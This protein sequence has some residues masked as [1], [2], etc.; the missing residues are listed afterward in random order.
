MIRI[1]SIRAY[2]VAPVQKEKWNLPLSSIMHT[3]RPK[4]IPSTL[5]LKRTEKIQG[6]KDVHS[7]PQFF[8]HV[9]PFKR[10]PK[11]PIWPTIHWYYTFVNALSEH[12]P[13]KWDRKE[14]SGIHYHIR[15]RNRWSGKLQKILASWSIFRESLARACLYFNFR[16]ISRLQL[17]H[18]RL[19]LP[20][21]ESLPYRRQQ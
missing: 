4:Q 7:S 8:L 14:T 20:E 10:Y 19:L 16:A 17:N 11:Y 3:K 18:R 9:C 1:W 6:L 5:P 21:A 12:T 2:S 13:F 15:C